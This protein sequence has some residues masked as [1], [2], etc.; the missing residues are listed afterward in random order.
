MSQTVLNYLP[1]FRE[2]GFQFLVSAE[3]EEFCPTSVPRTLP[4]ALCFEKNESANASLS[5]LFLSALPQYGSQT[6]TADDALELVG[7]LREAGPVLECIPPD[8][9]SY[10]RP[11]KV[12]AIL[13]S[14]C[15]IRLISFE[16]VV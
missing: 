3:E 13:A 7:L 16:R 4:I 8:R 6:L 14:R 2:N 1:V 5:C 12:R 11:S 9:M 10:L 15:V